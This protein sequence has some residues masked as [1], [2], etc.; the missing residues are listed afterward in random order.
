LPGV[1]GASLAKTSGFFIW[2]APPRHCQHS[3][4]IHRG[5]FP[6]WIA[7]VFALPMTKANASPGCAAL[8]PLPAM[9]GPAPSLPAQR[10]NPPRRLSC[11][12]CFGLR[13]PNDES[14]RLHSNARPYHPKL[15]AKGASIPH[16]HCPPWGAPLR[17]CQHSE[18]I[19]RGDC[20]V[21]IA[22]VFA[23]PMTKAP[24]STRICG[25]ITTARHGGPGPVIASTAK[26]STAGTVLSG[27][28]RSSPSQ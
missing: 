27:L 25:L 19:H 4:A 15:Q 24:A 21:W 2:G 7:S 1:F 10:S 20:P 11:L 12:D 13:P 26:Q 28:F 17:H 18:A 8:S 16:H 14:P 23:L 9:G 22:S 5:D 6:V 3:E